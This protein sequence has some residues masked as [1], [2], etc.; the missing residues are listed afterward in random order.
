[1]RFKKLNE[2]FD[3]DQE[4]INHARELVDDLSTFIDNLDI[5]KH[6]NEC[7]DADEIEAL[8]DAIE[9]LESFGIKYKAL[10]SQQLKDYYAS[11]G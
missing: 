10:A 11:K 5:Y 9:V 8:T 3:Y 4:A 6:A 7:I 1:M 2:A